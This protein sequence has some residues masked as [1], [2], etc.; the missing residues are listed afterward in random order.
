M[1]FKHEWKLNIIAV[2]VGRH[3]LLAFTI[4]RL[5]FILGLLFSNTRLFAICPSI[6][7]SSKIAKNKDDNMTIND[8]NQNPM[9]RFPS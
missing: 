3:F 2:L 4:H 1:W 8:R 7:F 6:Y 9:A 5:L